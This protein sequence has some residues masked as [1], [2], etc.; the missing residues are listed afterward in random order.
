MLTSQFVAR[1]LLELKGKVAGGEGVFE[2]LLVKAHFEEAKLRD[3][4]TSN[5]KAQQPT[6]VPQFHT[7]MKSTPRGRAEPKETPGKRI[8]SKP[9]STVT[10]NLPPAEQQIDATIGAALTDA[11]ATMYG[12]MPSCSG[13]ATLGFTIRTQVV[14]EGE[15][16]EALVDTGSPATIVSLKCIVDILAKQT[17]LGQSPQAWRLWNKDCVS[18]QFPS[19]TVGVGS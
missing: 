17:A 11:M 2:Q 6:T 14:L 16:V 5:R 3:L 12:V 7:E 10:P 19:R 15:K 18:R 4:N 8:P 9:V 1:L 13:V